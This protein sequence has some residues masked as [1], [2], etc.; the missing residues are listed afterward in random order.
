MTKATLTP[1]P[2]TWSSAAGAAATDLVPQVD[3]AVEVEHD[4]LEPAGQRLGGRG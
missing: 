1:S 3:D 4:P 2:R